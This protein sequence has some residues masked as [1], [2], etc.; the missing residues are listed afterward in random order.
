MPSTLVSVE[1]KPP[2]EYQ[3]F[4]CRFMGAIFRLWGYIPSEKIAEV[5]GTSVENVKKSAEK[6]GL[7]PD[8]KADPIWRRRGYITIIKNVWHMLSYDQ[9]CTLLDLTSA[10]FDTMLKED[11]FLFSKLGLIIPE[12]E[13]ALWR[14]LTSEEEKR[15]EWIK[16]NVTRLE[17]E[18]GEYKEKAFDFIN[19]YYEEDTLPPVVSDIKGDLRMVYSYFALYGDPLMEDDAN[20]FPD[21]LLREY[22]EY[23]INGIWFQAVLYQLVEFPFA[24]ELS[25]GYEKR[26]ENL[27]RIV[28]RA[29]KYGIGIYLYINEPRSMQESVFEKYPHLKGHTRN[30]EK[31]IYSMCTST[32]EVKE[33]LENALYTLFSE[34]EGLGGILTITAS[35]NQTHC[36]SHSTEETCTCERCKK[37]SAADVIS[38][39]NNVM[40]RGVKRAN[41]DARVICWDWSWPIDQT[42]DIIRK[43][44]RRVILQKTS[45]HQMEI[46]K[47]G[48]KNRVSDYTMSNPGPGPF[49]KEVWEV[50]R[51]SGLELS[52]KVQFNC[53][54]EMSA[55]PFIPAF[56][57]VAEHAENLKK[58]NIKHIMMSWTL[59]GSAS[60][61]I[62]LVND[63]MQKGSTVEDFIRDFYS[64][65]EWETVNRA[66]RELSKGFRE[67][68]FSCQVAYN[69]PQNGG[70]RSPFFPE[71]TGW[72]STMVGY[73]YDDID[74]WRHNYPADVFENQFRLVCEGNKRA[75]DIMESYEGKK[76]ERFI[77]TLNCMKGSYAHFL[78]SYN[79]IRFTRHRNKASTLTAEDIAFYGQ[80]FDSEEKNVRDA[81]K[82]LSEFSKFGFEATNHYSATR[83]DLI[84]KLINIEYMREYYEKRR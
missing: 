8:K 55:V 58:E 14:E 67:F 43:L 32:P 5:L 73:P 71:K 48:V 39:V 30:P 74:R 70:V 82:L 81:I 33:Y 7:D 75:I 22:A 66:Q 49:A 44:D 80:V 11:D 26:I 56:D 3:Y 1:K 24:P 54:W 69:A 6:M 37:R 51:E 15:A 17:K 57:L 79:L 62:S 59:G 2:L 76:S 60:P 61:N 31:K 46:V 28:K 29:A 41:P 40:A 12:S 19:K 36:Y 27:K 20:P 34:V 38:E 45:E 10:E 68:P 16:K 23:G 78:T 63:I 13:D 4:P 64:A 53:T 72:Y 25:R 21:K 52:A 18:L 35:E 42:A 50:G 47:G 84:E 9:I 77:D 83:Q 65:E